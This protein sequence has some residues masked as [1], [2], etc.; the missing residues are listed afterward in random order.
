MGYKGIKADAV[1][2]GLR[3]RGL[4]FF[5]AFT[6]IGTLVLVALGTWQWQRRAEKRAFIARIAEAAAQPPKAL[7]EAALWERVRVTG[8]F[9]A[10]KTVYV[11]TSRPAPKPGERDS[12]GRVPLSGFGVMVVTAFETERATRVGRVKEILLVNRGFLPTPPNG[13]IPAFDTPQNPVTLAGFLRPSEREGL[14]PP[15][16]DPAKGV[17][18]FRTTEQIASALGLPGSEIVEYPFY[19]NFLDRQAEPGE[20]T[21]P[22]GIDVPDL[23]KSI[24]NNH[25]EYAITWWSLAATNLAVAGFF[26]MGLRRRRDENAV[27]DAR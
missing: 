14:F 18:F 20:N 2:A 27:T 10:E 1:S 16:N 6:L 9:L 15:A 3:G 26:L 24:P 25:L 23:L 12:Q 21:P 13:A 22:F 17:F 8:R 11:R 5:L 4:T 7:G 19:T